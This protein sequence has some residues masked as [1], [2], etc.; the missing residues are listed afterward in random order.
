MDV[1]L[2]VVVKCATDTIMVSDFWEW[3]CVHCLYIYTR[4][5][6]LNSSMEPLFH[7]LVF[8]DKELQLISPHTSRMHL[9]RQWRKMVLTWKPS[10]SI[11]TDI[12]DV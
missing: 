4:L 1:S 2:R 11:N 5:C 12:C 9:K 6:V 8:P 7:A 10:S 3:I